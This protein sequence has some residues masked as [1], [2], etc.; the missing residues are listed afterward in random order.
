M[1]K[2]TNS[3]TY[4]NCTYNQINIIIIFYYTAQI[5]ICTIL[6]FQFSGSIYK[7]WANLMKYM[8]NNI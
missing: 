1:N 3:T 5:K 8:N 4:I 2:I 7:D 6:T